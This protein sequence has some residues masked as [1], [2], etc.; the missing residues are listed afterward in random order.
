IAIPID[1]AQTSGVVVEFTGPAAGKVL[2]VSLQGNFA[3]V[4]LDDSGYT[5]QRLQLHAGGNY[6]FTMVAV[7]EDGYPGP[8]AYANVLVEDPSKPYDPWGGNSDMTF[9]FV[10]P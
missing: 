9:E 1:E 3:I 6:A 2:I 7:D 4:D 10:D 8:R 5:R